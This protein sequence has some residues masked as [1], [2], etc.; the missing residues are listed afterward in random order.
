MTTANYNASSSAILS[1]ELFKTTQDVCSGDRVIRNKWQFLGEGYHSEGITSAMLRKPSKG[2]FNPFEKLHVQIESAI[3][4]SFDKDVQKILKAET[5]TLDQVQKGVKA[6]WKAQVG[7]LFNKIRSH[8]AE[9]EK[10]GDEKSTRVTR[11]KVDRIIDHLGDA[12][13]LAK[14]METPAFDVKAFDIEV[15]KLIAMVKAK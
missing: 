9:A 2:E 13:K 3:V 5:K 11:S 1:A 12:R 10:S 7:S 4:S 14:S 15:Q 6:Y 8:V